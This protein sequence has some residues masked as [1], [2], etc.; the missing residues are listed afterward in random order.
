MVS[1]TTLC[2]STQRTPRTQKKAE[3]GERQAGTRNETATS[4]SVMV[5]RDP[6]GSGVQ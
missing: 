2:S 3:M 6:K 5:S 4:H 1:T